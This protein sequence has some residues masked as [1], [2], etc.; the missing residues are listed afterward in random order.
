MAT[1]A[2]LVSTVGTGLGAALSAAEAEHEQVWE[3]P[4][5]AWAFGA[6]A[7]G[8]FLLLLLI[9]WFFRN[10]AHT[11]IYGPGGVREGADPIP[12]PDQH[13]QGPRH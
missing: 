11:M 2:S 7:L 4:M 13:H 8:L 3:L 9:T 10:T 5:P 1:L 12:H 6:V